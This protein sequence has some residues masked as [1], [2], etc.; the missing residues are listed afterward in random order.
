MIGAMQDISERDNYIQA[1]RTRNIKLKQIA[2]IRSHL[3]R[4]PLCRIMSL[5]DLLHDSDERTWNDLLPHLD[6]SIK[7]LDKIIFTIVKKAETALGLQ[8]N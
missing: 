4:A 2:W 3:V 7:E 6:S 1:I 5:C 8:V